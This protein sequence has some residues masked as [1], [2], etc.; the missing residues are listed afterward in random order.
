MA[1]VKNREAAEAYILRYLKMMLPGGK[2]VAI[3]ENLFK[4]M[5]DKDFDELMTKLE[6]GAEILAVITPN[7]SD[8]KVTVKNN[9][10]VA[11]AM[12]RTM[13]ERVWINPGDGSNPYLTPEKYFVALLPLRR[14][15]QL[16][17]K[18]ISI[19]ENNRSLN[20]LTGQPSHGGKSRGS[21]ISYPETQVLAALNLDESLLEML[22][23]RGGDVKGFGAMNKSISTTGG[24]SL[25]T[26]DT[27]GT[28][29]KS[30][31]T[32]RTLLTCLHYEV[33][34]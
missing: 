25:R 20:D 14:Q 30:T 21:K 12:N 27:L 22:K 18:K 24:V 31:D 10:A 11:K 33:D 34:L 23:Y 19:P 8:E 28:R 17:T 2:N 6:S 9:L 5:S 16:L 3:Y 7:L 1:E 4:S 13:F 29:V 26:L 32:L 15:A